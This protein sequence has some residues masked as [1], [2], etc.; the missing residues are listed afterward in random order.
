MHAI[1][2]S[3]LLWSRA[4]IAAAFVYLCATPG[5]AQIDFTRIPG[6]ARSIG[7]GANGATWVIGWGKAAGS[8]NYDIWR[9]AGTQWQKNSGSGVK[10]AVDP[11]GNALIVNSI[12]DIWRYTFAGNPP[13]EKLPPIITAAGPVRTASDIAVG[14]KGEIWILGFS[15]PAG[16]NQPIYRWTNGAWELLSGSGVQIAVAPNGDPWVVNKENGLWQRDIRLKTWIQHPLKFRSIAIGPTGAKFAVTTEETG[17]GNYK[18]VQDVGGTWTARSI[19]GV[20]VAVG[21]SGE[22]W[23]LTA[24]GEIFRG[25]PE[26]PF[27][28]NGVLILSDK[29]VI[30][31]LPPEPGLNVPAYTPPATGAWNRD[32]VPFNG[33]KLV[34]SGQFCPPTKADWV[35]PYQLDL[36]CDEGTFSPLYGGTC[37]A[38]PAND[39]LGN[40]WNINLLAVE[41]DEG[42]W[43]VPFPRYGKATWV[44]PGW[45]WDCDGSNGEFWDTH[46]ANGN[47]V[48]GGSC[49]KCADPEFPRR[50]PYFIA[51]PQA[52]VTP[53]QETSRPT[54]LT[55][56]G[57]P[58]PDAAAMGLKGKREPDKPF[59][60]I[61]GGWSAGVP[62]GGCF[63]CPVV[64][65]NGDIVVTSRNANSLANRNDNSGCDVRFRWTPPIFPEPGLSSLEGVKDVLFERNLL[66]RPGDISLFLRFTADAQGLDHAKTD[67]YVRSEWLKIT[68]SPYR[69]ATVRSLVFVYLREIVEKSPQQRTAAEK[70]LLASFENYIRVRRTFLAQQALNMYDAW[71]AADD[72]HRQTYQRGILQD[73]FYYGTV[74]LDFHKTLQSLTA[75]GTTGGGIAGAIA[76][77]YLFVKNLTLSP[78]H[79]PAST[80]PTWALPQGDYYQPSGTPPSGS[81]R[82]QVERVAMVKKPEYNGMA[83]MKVLDIFKGSR[84]ALSIA[85]GTT[86]IQAAFAVLQS[87]AID[88]FVAIITARPKLE[89]ALAAADQPVNLASLLNQYNGE[90]IVLSYWGKAMDV[91]SEKDDP[92]LVDMAK[93]A[94]AKAVEKQFWW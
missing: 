72:Q 31:E 91:E 11:A 76:T 88:Q 22:P 54:L 40:P 79:L 53:V 8:E 15:Q 29:L 82:P 86:I 25:T 49:W 33:G 46:D 75:L 37:W 32:L 71:K 92:Q 67:E 30:S 27:N 42:C 81:A 48:F 6:Q 21:P 65:E 1:R 59:L 13:W 9:W 41:K 39:G 93:A 56:N 66:L 83:R 35:G 74:P 77:E 60:D 5:A 16:E 36:T 34:C 64:D 7:V 43:R 38:C 61:A 28:S 87:I 80:N 63:S 19:S 50:T 26:A 17:S 90:D 51:G 10:I 58:H 20:A 2:V 70:K 85:G 24:A 55:F 23:V 73:L 45:A 78:Y 69:S 84:T 47:F 18:I 3:S 68:Q 89:A 12:G 44:K 4:A 62:A 94:Y 57:C 52:C 14:P